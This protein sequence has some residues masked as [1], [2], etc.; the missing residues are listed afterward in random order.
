MP[1]TLKH[2]AFCEFALSLVVI[3]SPTGVVAKYCDEYVCL[4]V[5]LS[6]FSQEYLRNHTRG[7]YQFFC[8]CCLLPWLGPPTEWRNPK[9]KGQ[10]WEFS[11]LLTIH[12]NAFAAKK[13][14]LEW[15]DGSAQR[16]RSVIYNCLVCNCQWTWLPLLLLLRCANSV[17]T[18]SARGVRLITATV[19][20]VLRK[21]E[22]KQHDAV[23]ESKYN[24]I[25]YSVNL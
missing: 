11:S 8:G 6:V 3:T 12:C 17:K 25:K 24:K 13:I 14:G 23:A 16:G 5:Y 18:V 7:V 15:S 22:K 1:T 2:Y 19:Y 9:A 21:T 20:F 10:F 4:S